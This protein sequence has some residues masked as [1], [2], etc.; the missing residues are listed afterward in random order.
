[1]AARFSRGKPHP[2]ADPLPPEKIDNEAEF[3]LWEKFHDVCVKI[4]QL[5]RGRHL[6]GRAPNAQGQLGWVAAVWDG[7]LAM[8]G[9]AQVRSA[10]G[11]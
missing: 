4:A 10:G 6:V 11:V 5:E 2:R 3:D 9:T 8:L 1:M 7:R